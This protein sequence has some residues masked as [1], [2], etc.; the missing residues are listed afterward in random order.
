M[1]SIL[2]SIKKAIGLDNDYS[3]FD[4]DIIMCINTA[5]MSLTQIGVGPSE[6]FMVKDASQMW[7]DL[8]GTRKDL[9]SVKTYVYLKVRLVFDPP[10][11]GVLLDAMKAMITEFE[12]RL[13][14]QVEGGNNG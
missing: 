8:I 9:E 11:T 7:T 2:K 1:D 12:W 10:Q 5:I 4:L 13:S 14:V 6:G 3:Q